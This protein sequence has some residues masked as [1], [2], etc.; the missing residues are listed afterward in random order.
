MQQ[1]N[2]YT[3]FVLKACT[4][5][6]RIIKSGRSGVPVAKSYE[7]MKRLKRWIEFYGNKGSDVIKAWFLR[8]MATIEAVMPPNFE[9][10]L[11]QLLDEQA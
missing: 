8:E 10:K 1:P 6:S 5:R 2:P 9:K 3:S 11:N 7:D 4:A